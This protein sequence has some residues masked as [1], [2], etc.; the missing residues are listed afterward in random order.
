LG[1]LH[2][3][4]NTASLSEKFAIFTSVWPLHGSVTN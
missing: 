3:E 4:A 2:K 1:I